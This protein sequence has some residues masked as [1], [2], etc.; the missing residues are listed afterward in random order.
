MPLPDTVRR[1]P[2]LHAAILA[3]GNRW[4]AIAGM[5]PRQRVA[6][7]AGLLALATALVAVGVAW[8][9]PAEALGSGLAVIGPSVLAVIAVSGGF[10]CLQR[11][12]T[13][14]AQRRR[15][16]LAALPM[17]TAAGERDDLLRAVLPVLLAQ[18]AA[19]VL[20]AG[21][22]RQAGLAAWAFAGIVLANAFGL[23]RGRRDA[24]RR[25]PLLRWTAAIRADE[26]GLRAL[27]RWPFRAALA[28]AVPRTQALVLAALLLLLPVGTT[29][30]TGLLVILGWASLSFLSALL[31][32]TCTVIPQAAQWLRA[33]PLPGRRFAIAVAARTLAAVA[34]A[35]A[36]TGL[37]FALLDGNPRA[38]LLVAALCFATATTLIG[39]TL[40]QRFDV[41]RGQIEWLACA[42][43]GVLAGVSVPVALVPLFVLAWS[44]QW[45]RLR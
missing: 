30:V 20:V 12:R 19:I 44:G 3:G 33:T 43:V 29:G 23:H 9:H 22:S 39:A 34:A 26:T 40:V 17:V 10:A 7:A 24:A 15:S 45:L 18:V 31:R 28:A 1:D 38:G 35:A 37:A 14:R 32:G 42:V 4:R 11:R 8:R 16:W 2:F 27:G 5:P 6:V 41:R 13:L 36:L 25:T 21:T